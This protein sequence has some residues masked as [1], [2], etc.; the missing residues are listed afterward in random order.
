MTKREFLQALTNFAKEY[1]KDA[2]ESVKRNNHMNDLTGK[3]EI[4]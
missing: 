1:R 4:S 2:I 3:E